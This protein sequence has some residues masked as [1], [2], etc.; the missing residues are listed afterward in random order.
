SDNTS[1][2]LASNNSPGDPVLTVTGKA[3]GN[4]RDK[5]IAVTKS[6]VHIIDELRIGGAQTHLVTMLRYAVQ[7][8][9]IRHHVISLF[10]DG[11]IGHELRDMGVET[12]ALNLHLELTRRRF[13]EA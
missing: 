13:D 8:Y 12:I 5:G 10:G 6:V 4:Y 11:P 1:C 2:R 3:D 9:P 7:R